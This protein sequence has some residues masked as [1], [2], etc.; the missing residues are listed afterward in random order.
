[1]KLAH[2][3][4][5]HLPY[6]RR[7]SRALTGSQSSGDSYV[8]ALLEA[9]IAN[10]A[11]F[12]PKPNTRIAIY[13]SFCQLWQSFSLNLHKSSSGPAWEDTAQ[14]Q[15]ANINLKARVAFLLVAVE[16]FTVSEAALILNSSNTETKMLLEEASDTI[17]RQ[18]A[19]DVMI[20]EDEPLIAM[21]LEAL[22]ESLGHRVIGITRTEKEAVRLAAAKRPGL[23]LADIQL[24]DGSS[25]VDAVRNILQSITVPV[26]FITA[27][28][29][30]LLTGESPEPIYLI[31]KPFTPEMVKAMVSQVLFFNEKASVD[32]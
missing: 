21:E 13:R 27:L 19:T 11:Q 31:T 7:F 6:L 18:V 14:R 30:R 26:I 9:L 22:L 8:A 1:M 29:E 25:G 4:A 2:D 20:I 15:L 17:L 12:D 10:P 3:I 16:G 23:V 32:S 28:P 5:P 24:A